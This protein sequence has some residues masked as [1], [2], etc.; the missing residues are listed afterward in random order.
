MKYLKWGI[1]VVIVFIALYFVWP[2][3]D[4]QDI[5]QTSTEDEQP[6]ILLGPELFDYELNK[7]KWRISAA[8]AYIYEKRNITHLSGINGRIF[9]DD[10]EKKPT[11]IFAESGTIKADSHTLIVKGNVRINFNDGQEVFTEELIIDQG[12]AKIYN[13]VDVLVVSHQDTMKA[14]SMSYDIKSGQLVL[15]RPRIEF[16]LNPEKK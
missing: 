5:D 2:S 7:I 3:Y 14:S 13:R 6:M 16:I 8:K 15:V 12:K 4:I 9:S 11:L 10:P 1:L